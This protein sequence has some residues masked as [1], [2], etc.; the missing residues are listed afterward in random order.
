MDA[1]PLMLKAVSGFNGTE[2]AVYLVASLAGYSQMGVPVFGLHDCD[3]QGKADRAI[4]RDVRHKPLLF[5]WAGLAAAEM[6]A[7]RSSTRRA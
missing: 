2:G 7:I 4:P 6:R 3:V 1:D 5:A